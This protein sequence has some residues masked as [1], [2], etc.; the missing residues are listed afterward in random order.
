MR[1]IIAFSILFI[2]AN[3]ANAEVVYLQCEGK[4]SSGET[5]SKSISFSPDE[6]WA[7][8]GIITTS[9]GVKE[10][11]IFTLSTKIIRESG[12]CIIYG[13][14]RGKCTKVINKF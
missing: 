11:I 12:D 4:N 2:V 6:L 8:D 10:N 3:V 14:F 5:K 1:K 7:S 9:D 13:E